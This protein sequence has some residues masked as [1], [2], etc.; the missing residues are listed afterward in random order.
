[1]VDIIRLNDDPHS[2][3]QQLLPWY[4]TG[5]LGAE[6]TAL[7]E[8][9]LGECAECR[10]DLEM[11][12]MLARQIKALPGDT[13]QGWAALKSRIAE[14]GPAKL[15]PMPTR[16]RAGLWAFAGAAG[17]AIAASFATFLV[18]RP[19]P[20]YQTLG[21]PPGASTGNVVV[22]FKPDCP[23]ASFRAVLLQNQARIVDGP[24]AAAA[25]VLHVASDQRAAVLAR[26][27]TDRNVAVAE[28]IDG[29]A[30]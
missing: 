26:L 28:A 4:V 20:V 19:A 1:M 12:T 15:L 2:Q 5:T 7:V 18:M 16:R 21:A 6:E 10:E 29:D 11:E 25:Y 27:K 9:H 30:R 22:I 13:D 8:K 3:S 14:T 24:T 17:M 23:E